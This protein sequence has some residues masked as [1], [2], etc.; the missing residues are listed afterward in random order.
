MKGQII[1]LSG[2][3]FTVK[4]QTETITLSA[5]GKLKKETILVGDFV[6]YANGCIEKIYPRSSSFI[7]PAV[8]NID[9]VLA[10]ISPVPKPDYTILDK[11]LI[12]AISQGVEV[13]IVINK[14]DIE[15]ELP[16][17]V[18]TEYENSGV[19]IV[20]I[21]AKNGE[22]IEQLKTLMKGKF[23]ALA[24]QSAVGKS[25]LVNTLFGLQLKTG[26]VSEKIGR[27]KHTTT[28][29]TVYDLD[30]YKI[31]DTP[32]FYTLESFVTPEE[33][34]EYYPEFSSVFG[35]CKFRGCSHTG[36]IGCAVKALVESGEISK[37]RYERYIEIYKQLKDKKQLY[38]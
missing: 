5:R 19:K 31:I 7:R 12:S 30:G 11:L 9:L 23:T 35:K 20:T 10:V 14:I 17:E 16:T 34:G 18:N 13:V 21:S 27:G 37:G 6:E 33:L 28:K 38:K 4:S 36:E 22:N 1:S 29:S 25:T 8:A 24:G 26:E 2:N 32:G 15:S 3:S